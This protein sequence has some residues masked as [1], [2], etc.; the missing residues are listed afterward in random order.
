MGVIILTSGYTMEVQ[1]DAEA[2]RASEGDRARDE[3]PGGGVDVYVGFVGCPIQQG[4][5]QAGQMVVRDRQ[6][7][8][9]DTPLSEPSEVLLRDEGLPVLQQ[10]RAEGG[11][12]QRLAE[13]EFGLGGRAFEGV[14]SDPPFEREPGACERASG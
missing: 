3:L 8:G 13:G 9:V 11:G 6:A 4:R 14:G 5:V 12:G 7:E 2:V 1:K 10:P